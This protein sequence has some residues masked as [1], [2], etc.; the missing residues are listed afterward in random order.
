MLQRQ[1]E[2]AFAVEQSTRFCPRSKDELLDDRPEPITQPASDRYGESHLLPVE[3][4]RGH[5]VG[6]R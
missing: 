6:D 3:D 4:R 5:E 2:Y 1:S